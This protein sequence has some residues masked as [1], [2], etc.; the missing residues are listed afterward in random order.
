MTR[1]T[2]AALGSWSCVFPSTIFTSSRLAFPFGA[3]TEPLTI[4]FMHGARRIPQRSGDQASRAQALLAPML[5][6][7]EARR[8]RSGPDLA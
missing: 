5:H 1:T 2:T 6:E 8:R 7:R 3:G 4:G